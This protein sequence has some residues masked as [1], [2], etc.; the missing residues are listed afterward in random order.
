MW[1]DSFLAHSYVV[2]MPYMLLMHS[3][4][5]ESNYVWTYSINVWDMTHSYVRDMTHSYVLL[6]HSLH[7]ESKYVWT[8]SIN[9]C[10]MTHSYVRDMTHS[11]VQHPSFISYGS[12]V[13]VAW[14]MPTCGIAHSWQIHMWCLCSL[15][16]KSTHDCTCSIHVCDM[17]HPCVW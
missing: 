15:L 9:V 14:L 1:R 3:L 11:S 17:T 5:L 7:L 8:C 12:F 6:M 2:L 13:F 4:H 16:L 10:D